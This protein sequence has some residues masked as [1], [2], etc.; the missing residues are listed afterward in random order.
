MAC[1]AGVCRLFDLSGRT[2]GTAI[3]AADDPVRFRTK[4]TCFPNKWG[5]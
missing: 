5:G 3:Q 2:S 1:R 4:S